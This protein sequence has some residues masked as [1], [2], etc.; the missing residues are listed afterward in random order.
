MLGL[1]LGVLSVVVIL[2]TDVQDG[3]GGVTAGGLDRMT[4]DAVALLSAALAGASQVGHSLTFL[5]A[6]AP[7]VPLSVTH[8]LTHQNSRLLIRGCIHVSLDV[9]IEHF[10]TL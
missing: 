2:W 1:V 6:V 5:D 4:G 3:R 9:S 10:G 8:L 7:L